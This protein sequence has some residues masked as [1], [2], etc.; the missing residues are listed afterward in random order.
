MCILPYHMENNLLL[1]LT[2][3]NIFSFLE[4][5]FKTAKIFCEVCGLFSP[6]CKVTQ[7][8]EGFFCH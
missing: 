1:D 2:T 4:G 5:K 6:N 8:I 7:W 3:Y